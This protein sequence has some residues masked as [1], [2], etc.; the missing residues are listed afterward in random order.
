MIDGKTIMSWNVPAIHDGDPQEFIKLMDS[1][2][3]EGVM[4][5]AGDGSRI[6]TVSTWSPWPEWGENIRMDLVEALK[7]SKKKIYLWHFNYG[8][9]PQGELDVARQ[10]SDRFEP[11][12]YVWNVEGS[13]ENRSN[14]EANARLI[15]RGFQATHPHIPQGLCTWALHESPTTGAEWHPKRVALAF[16]EIGMTGLPM[17]Y[18]QGIGADAAVSY[19]H[20]SLRIWRDMTDNPICPIGRSYNGD[21]GYA[22]QESIKAFADEVFRLAP[23]NNLIGNSWYSLDKAVQ[24]LSWLVSLQDA[25]EYGAGRLLTDKE[26]LDILVEKHPEFFPDLDN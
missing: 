13:F 24:K 23:D 25:P 20:K 4:L 19:L 2:G 17:M 21:G 9:N 14:A 15:S 5:K 8:Y 10:Q 26:K 7:A 12:G 22:D 11:D 6:Q 3:M 16:L 18:W 1:L